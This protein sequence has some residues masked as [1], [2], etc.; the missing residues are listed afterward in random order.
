VDRDT[1][2]RAQ[3]AGGQSSRTDCRTFAI[4][5][6]APGISSFA[7]RLTLRFEDKAAFVVK[8]F[9]REGLDTNFAK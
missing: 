4:L 8:I 6:A 9:L 1:R 7:T 3:C 5:V 2:R